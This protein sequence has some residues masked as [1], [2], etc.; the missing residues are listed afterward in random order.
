[1]AEIKFTVGGD[2]T[3][4]A[5][6]QSI[7]EKSQKETSR[8]YLGASQIGHPCHRK[9]FYSFRYC[10]KKI[11]N[12]N[13]DPHDIEMEL[14]RIK[15]VEDGRRQEL[16]IIENLRRV[17]GVEVYSDDGTLD[18]HGNPNQIGFEMLLG[19]FRGHLDGVIT[20]LLQAP[21]TPHVFEA[22]CRKEEFV[23][24]LEKKKQKFGE[25]NAL[26]EW[27][28][29][30][31]GQAQIYMHAMELERH[32][33]VCMS[34]GGRREISCRTDYNKK[35]AEALIE[36][37]QRI[38]FD[39]EYLPPRMSNNRE[40]FECKWC[41]YQE[42]CHDG[43]FPL[44]NCKTCRYITPGKDGNFHCNKYEELLFDNFLCAYHVYN[45][46]L[47]QAELLEQEMDGNI[48]KLGKIIFANV[49]A[50]G[51]PSMKY[52]IQ[53]IFT[54]EMLRDQVKFVGLIQGELPAKEIK[55]EEYSIKKKSFRKKS[56]EI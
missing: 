43:R 42:I 46:A 12:K 33:L 4:E 6:N 38:I 53:G 29:E 24:D 16:L 52:D 37:A 14:N 47:V 10:E 48:Y 15:S 23:R 36:K 20:G 30:Y 44:V 49:Y 54:S 31:Y 27:S 34:P 1:M 55:E 41:L 11:V 17:P 8:G 28:P 5:M 51:L 13:S 25:K 19:H 22:K 18:E 35:D 39:D 50:S 40:Y 56:V 32:Y 21:K 45:P 2:P 26:R 7:L 9:L 3:I